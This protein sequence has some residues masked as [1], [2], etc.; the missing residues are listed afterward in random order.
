MLYARNGAKPYETGA[1][2]IPSLTNK[3]TWVKLF[4]KVLS[5]EVLGPESKPRQ[6][7]SRTLILYWS[8]GA[9]SVAVKTERF[10][11]TQ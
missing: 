2:I 5:L 11:V 8:T 4:P 1:V 3:E 6:C 9:L 7:N 10:L